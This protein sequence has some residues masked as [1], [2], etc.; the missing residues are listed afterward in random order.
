MDLYPIK[1]CHTARIQPYLY[2]QPW[3]LT[4]VLWSLSRLFLVPRNSSSKEYLKFSYFHP[5]INK[6]LTVK[7]NN[8]NS[9]KLMSV[10]FI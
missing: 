10:N 6:N 1:L 4:T 2:P 9:C 7:V 3:P 8:L 5:L